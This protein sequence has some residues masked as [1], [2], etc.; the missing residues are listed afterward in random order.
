ML[1]LRRFLIP[2][3]L[4]PISTNLLQLNFSVWCVSVCPTPLSNS[5]HKLAGRKK[6]PWTEETTTDYSYSGSRYMVRKGEEIEG[7]I[8]SC[9]TT[10]Y[11]SF[12]HWRRWQRRRTGM[13][14]SSEVPNRS[15][16][17]RQSK[18]IFDR[19]W[20]LLHKQARE[21]RHL[22]SIWYCQAKCFLC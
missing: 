1:S 7:R 5:A 6:C 16:G 20:G 18:K 14:P 22:A 19:A 21:E 2:A 12:S 4:R 3:E 10:I 17:P 8:E 15:R 9:W 13:V 11:L